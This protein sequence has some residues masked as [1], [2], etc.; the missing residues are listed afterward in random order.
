MKV[1][2]VRGLEED[3]ARFWLERVGWDPSEA[4]RKIAQENDPNTTSYIADIGG[5]HGREALWLAEQGFPSILVEPNKY[6]LAFAKKRAKNKRLNVHL[7]GAA[8]PYLPIRPEAISIVELYWTLH[9]IPDEHKPQSLKEIHRILKPLGTAYST[10]FGHWEG[11][12]MP[13]SIYPIMKKETFKHLHVAAGLN[14]RGKI[15]E[16]SD[17]TRPFEKFWY[18]M[19][20]KKNAPL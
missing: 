16:R 4:A 3:G 17:S 10:S 1:S 12:A 13:S 19:F 2:Y 7:I 5:G 14:P 11:H 9:Q 6:S 15:E 20:Q 8:L 18:G